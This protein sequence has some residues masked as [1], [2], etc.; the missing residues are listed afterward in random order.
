[1]TKDL[2][3]SIRDKYK[4]RE[5]HLYHAIEQYLMHAEDRID[6][7]VAGKARD[8]ERIEKIS[9]KC[10]E[11]MEE[12]PEPKEYQIDPNMDIEDLLGENN[13]DEILEAGR[14]WF[15]NLSAEELEEIMNY[16]EGR[17]L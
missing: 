9:Q 16:A 8:R 17:K 13:I 12:L 10:R 5:A 2:K 3:R 11:L 4:R 1:M 7:S 6:E 15:E 14:K